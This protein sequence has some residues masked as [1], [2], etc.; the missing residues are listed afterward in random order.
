MSNKESKVYQFL[1]KSDFKIRVLINSASAHMG[2]SLVLLKNILKQIN[3]STAPFYFVVIVPNE[4]AQSLREYEDINKL[5]I[6]SYPS[7][8]TNGVY[9]FFH[10]QFFIPW[11]VYK[12][13]INVVF[14]ITGFASIF[15][16]CPQ[17]LLIRN[18]LYFDPIIYKKYKTFGSNSINRIIRR[19]W[20]S[21]VSIKFSDTVIFPTYSIYNMV[22]K[23]ISLDK[24]NIKVIHYGFD[25]DIFLR[26]IIR[27]N[28]FE[29]KIT[30]WKK[31]GFTILLNISTYAVHKNLETVIEALN[32]LIKD[33]IKIKFVLTISRE[34]TREKKEF[35]AL[36]Q[37]IKTLGLTDIVFILGYVLHENL[38]SL[39]A[40]ADVFVFPSM[41][42]S[43]G[44]PLL[45]A[46]AAGLP[47][48][49]SDTPTNRE[50]CESAATYFSTFD[51][52]FCYEALKTVLNNSSLREN[53]HKFSL[54]QS[55]KFSWELYYQELTDV[56][57][58]LVDDMKGN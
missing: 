33:N 50:V 9:R 38:P 16:S 13:D 53:M 47:M 15:L 40:L 1:G 39:Y 2:G 31:E 22:K 56:F 25:N 19:R 41:I 14:S 4:L 54:L 37:R 11:L 3:K 12:L 10:D 7:F 18:L 23:H 24:K 36:M 29:Q 27:N 49:V 57:L 46:M 21:L 34:D 8:S 6:Y 45:E 26:D 48:V 30:K 52:N 35:D 44:H 28:D 17:V 32:M 42:E 20:W 5:K 55:Q 58:G 43:F 51:S